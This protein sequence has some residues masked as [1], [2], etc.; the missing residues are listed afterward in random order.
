MIHHLAP[1]GKIGL[2]LAN[3]A[4]SSQSSGEGDIRKNIIQADLVEGIV[5][6]PTQLFYSVTIPVTLW[7]ISKNKKQKGTTLFIDA[8][9]MGYMVD[10]KHRDFTDDDIQ[11]LADTFTAFQ[12]GTLEDVK[13]FCAVADLQEIEKQDFIL[14]PGRDLLSRNY[15]VL[16]E[17]VNT[18]Y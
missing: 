6:L 8:R 5:A 10:R 1:N 4:L 2:V 13:G 14:T 3:G 15:A 7:F 12:E 11:K 9:K 18:I 16:P 17:I